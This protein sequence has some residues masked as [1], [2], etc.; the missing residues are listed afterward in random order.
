M[1]KILLIVL[2]TPFSLVSQVRYPTGVININTS[3]GG[4]VE[5]IESTISPPKNSLYVYENWVPTIVILRNDIGAVE[6]PMRFDILNNHIEIKDGLALKYL[7]INFIES[8][9]FKSPGGLGESKF[10]ITNYTFN[11]PEKHPF[12][13]YEVLNEG[14]L[15]LLKY[16]SYVRLKPDYNPALDVGSRESRLE[17]VFSYF[18]MSENV[19]VELPKSKKKIAALL[20]T[21][22]LDAKSIIKE[23]SWNLKEESDLIQ[24]INYCNNN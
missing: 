2:L 24:I 23:N 17:K 18:I 20:E 7:E 6:K 4:I 8:L 12:G 11:H 19:P 3:V 15:N 21:Y 13:V 5:K 1:R 22:C 16:H 10:F 14:D 9:N